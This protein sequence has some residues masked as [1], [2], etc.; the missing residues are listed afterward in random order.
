MDKLNFLNNN[1][2]KKKEN[3]DIT[4]SPDC[5]IAEENDQLINESF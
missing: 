3:V 4:C 2:K 5:A 1:K